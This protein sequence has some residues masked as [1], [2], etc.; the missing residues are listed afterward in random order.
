MS[1]TPTKYKLIKASRAGR[2]NSQ[3]VDR[4]W[5]MRQARRKWRHLAKA[6]DKGLLRL[7]KYMLLDGLDA[8]GYLFW[9][10]DFT[11]HIVSLGDAVRI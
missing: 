3:Y 6:Q 10:D 2:A 5:A 1:Q 7:G 8:E 4:S 9:D 11:N